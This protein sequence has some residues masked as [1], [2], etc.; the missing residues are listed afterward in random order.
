MVHRCASSVV[1]VLVLVGTDGHRLRLRLQRLLLDG[2]HAGQQGV[3]QHGA[4]RHQGRQHLLPALV[5]DVVKVAAFGR[6]RWR[7]GRLWT[8]GLWEKKKGGGK[9]HV[10]RSES[11]TN[12]S[13]CQL[14]ARR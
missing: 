9:I 1:L 11:P 5:G 12:A 14:V 8:E 6:R 13:S 7:A 10:S 4:Q 3:A 2:H